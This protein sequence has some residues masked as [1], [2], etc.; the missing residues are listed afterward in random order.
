MA[1]KR[2]GDGLELNFDGLTDAVTNLVGSL[3]LLVVLVLGMSRPK[4]AD[5]GAGGASAAQQ[6][7]E[8]LR[9]EIRGLHGQVDALEPQ[10]RQ[11]RERAKALGVE[12]SDSVQV[13]TPPAT[14]LVQRP[15]NEER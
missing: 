2:R 13:P 12:T 15:R 8:S 5:S 1:R 9:L 3:L 7:L 11:L 4:A 10:L 6:Q 14:E